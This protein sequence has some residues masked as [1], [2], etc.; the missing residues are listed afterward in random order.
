M[1][2]KVKV[3]STN[4]MSLT[5]AMA[6]IAALEGQLE[7]YQQAG[8]LPDLP[9]KGRL[10]GRITEQPTLP[11]YLAQPKSYLEGRA[12]YT[13]KAVELLS[14]DGHQPSVAQ[15]VV[16]AFAGTQ[17]GKVNPIFENMKRK[18]E[19]SRL[20][21]VFVG[22]GDA[23]GLDYGQRCGLLGIPALRDPLMQSYMGLGAVSDIKS[24]AKHLHMPVPTSFDES[25]RDHVFERLTQ[26]EAMSKAMATVDQANGRKVDWVSWG[27]QPSESLHLMRDLTMEEIAV[28]GSAALQSARTGWRLTQASVMAPDM[29][30]KLTPEP[31]ALL[32]SGKPEDF[33]KVLLEVSDLASEAATKMAAA[34]TPSRNPLRPLISMF[35]RRFG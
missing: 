35:Q 11:P 3:P 9:R 33:A 4:D 22:V 24:E 25:T 26:I 27:Q 19:L 18:D 6:R 16:G 21:T 2:D 7:R 20:W 31:V 23:F 5:E 10:S 34:P 1:T 8:L 13:P 32:T 12:H 30:A 15:P 28:A 29:A 17:L 14:K